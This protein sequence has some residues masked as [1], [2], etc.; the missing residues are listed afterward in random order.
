M[1]S[2]VIAAHVDGDFP[3][4]LCSP[5]AFENYKRQSPIPRSDMPS[6][7]A[8]VYW[9]CVRLRVINLTNVL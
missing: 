2:S 3:R 5:E 8:G 6:A 7:I 4:R 1:L 9:V